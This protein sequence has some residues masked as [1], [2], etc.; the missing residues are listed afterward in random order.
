MTP[1]TMEEKLYREHID[2]QY[3]IIDLRTGAYTTNTSCPSIT[4]KIIR[5]FLYM[6]D[7][8]T[9][10]VVNP[11]MARIGAFISVNRPAAFSHI[12]IGHAPASYKEADRVPCIYAHASEASITAAESE[13]Y[14]HIVSAGIKTISP[15]SDSAKAV[16]E[17]FG[18]F[19]RSAD[20]LQSSGSFNVCAL[21]A[22]WEQL[23]MTIAKLY[24]IQ[25]GKEI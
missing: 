1:I 10:K 3:W 6:E 4:P 16:C 25:T 20:R 2:L 15:D 14:N 21:Q 23:N 9:P 17:A 22:K 13:A 8:P 19:V 7:T 12:Y 18:D 11:P 24:K 5:Q